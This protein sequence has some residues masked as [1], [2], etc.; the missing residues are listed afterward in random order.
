MFTDQGNLIRRAVDE[1][2]ISQAA[3]TSKSL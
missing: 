1:N 3:L 2:H